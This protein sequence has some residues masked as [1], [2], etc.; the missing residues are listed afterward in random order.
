VQ[1]DPETFDSLH[2]KPRLDLTSE[3]DRYD[4]LPTEE[5][6]KRLQAAWSHSKQGK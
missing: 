3:M 1:Y 2:D 6:V 4:K 5:K